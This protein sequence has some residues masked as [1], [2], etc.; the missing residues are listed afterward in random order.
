MKNS[1][2]VAVSTMMVLVS[3]TATVTVA[4]LAGHPLF[5]VGAPA[6]QSHPTLTLPPSVVVVNRKHVLLDPVSPAAKPAAA[7]A[8]APVDAEG[9][10][11][12]EA[13]ADGT[14]KATPDQ[15]DTPE[16]VV[17]GVKAEAFAPKA[18]ASSDADDSE[19]KPAPALSSSTPATGA[20]K[21]PVPTTGANAPVTTIAKT[22]ATTTHVEQ[23][24]EHTSRTGSSRP[25]TTSS[26]ETEHHSS[27]DDD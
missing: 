27:G 2:A 16:A 25:A 10:P 20:V 8:G 18:S 12:A 11:A 4:A 24:A 26:R 21:A 14:S 6:S 23:Q 7:A 5:G 17:L 9:A 19:Q 22:P 15:A 13:A 1:K 3:V